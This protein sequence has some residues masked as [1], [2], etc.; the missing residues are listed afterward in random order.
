MVE[1][2]WYLCISA[3]FEVQ[4]TS[5][6]PSEF[7]SRELFFNCFHVPLQNLCIIILCLC[8]ILHSSWCQLLCWCSAAG[9]KKKTSLSSEN[10]SADASRFCWNP[11]WHEFV[12]S[13]LCTCLMNCGGENTFVTQHLQ[14]Y[15][16]F[17]R[18]DRCAANTPQEFKCSLTTRMVQ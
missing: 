11:R 17:I 16:A 4:T 1:F 12:W 18:F 6:E 10:C 7:H 5:I 15:S 3:G 8:N 13:H 9:R 14:F 2:S